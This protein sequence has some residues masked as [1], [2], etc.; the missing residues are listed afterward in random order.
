MS[1]MDEFTRLKKAKEEI[2]HYEWSAEGKIVDGLR[3]F[4]DSCGRTSEH[5]PTADE[6]ILLRKA[7]TQVEH[8]GADISYDPYKVVAE[9]IRK[10]LI[11]Y[12]DKK[13]RELAEKAKDE[14]NAVLA[15]WNLTKITF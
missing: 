8:S 13:L 3:M 5:H 2:L 4:S 6:K 15:Y 12:C 9:G 11:H 10:V 7:M 14:A 1:A